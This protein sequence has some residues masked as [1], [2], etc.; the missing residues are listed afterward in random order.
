MDRSD[1]D[2]FSVQDIYDHIQRNPVVPLYDFYRFVE[3]SLQYSQQSLSL[4]NLPCP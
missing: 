3:L 2:L 4:L 1:T